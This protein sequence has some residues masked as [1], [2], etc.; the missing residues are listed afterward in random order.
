MK[1]TI[2]IDF[3]EFVNVFNEKGKSES[4][5][6][7]KEKYNL[8]FVQIKRRMDRYTDYCFDL[9]LRMYKHKK[10]EDIITAEFMSIDEL[11]SHKTKDTIIREVVPLSGPGSNSSYDELVKD[12][13]KDRII[14]LSKYVS[15][16]QE[17]RKLVINT[18][19]LKRDDF[20]L[21]II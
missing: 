3:D 7:A 19:N 17:T 21:V 1:N 10:Q 18:K 12:L 14:I 15:L 11:N 13:I 4:Q 8:S 6:L 2:D 5:L 16:E 20:D 9:S